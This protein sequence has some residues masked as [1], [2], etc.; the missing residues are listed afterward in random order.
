MM[1]RNYQIIVGLIVA[2]G[3]CG[4]SSAPTYRT[5]LDGSP[6]GRRGIEP[7]WVVLSSYSTTFVV[8]QSGRN[9]N[10]IKAIA[11]INNALLAPGKRLSF[12]GRVGRR[13]QAGGWR[14]APTLSVEGAKP[15]VGGGICLVSSTTYN[16][17]L[18]AD[19]RVVERHPHSRPIRYIPLGRDATV[20][21]GNKDLKAV[22]THDIPVRLRAWVVGNRVT[23]QVQAPR[24]L[25]YEVRLETAD[26]EPASLRRPIQILKRSNELAVGGVWVKLYRHRIRDGSVYQTERIGRSSFYPFQIKS[27]RL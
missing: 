13:T 15:A 11:R 14:I 8:G 2:A 10:I 17:L 7:N 18:L 3:I 12:N 26:S 6:M 19:L 9:H 22:N 21:W 20:D 16:A 4:C 5:E 25:G 23:V 24:R 1:T 27:Q